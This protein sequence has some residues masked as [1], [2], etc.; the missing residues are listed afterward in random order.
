MTLDFKGLTCPH[1]I[2]ESKKILDKMEEGKIMLMI[3]NCLGTRDDIYSWVKETKNEIVEIQEKD[4]GTFYF[5]IKKG[6]GIAIVPDVT[7]D[8][9]G[10][11]YPCPII[12]SKRILNK[13][14]EGKIMLM[15]SDCPG[16]RD[17]VETC[18]NITGNELLDVHEEAR[19]V[20]AF[21]IK[22]GKR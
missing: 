6:K 7:L 8:F 4:K 21:Y 20:Y 3:S 12:E 10:L 18:V 2:I 13:M 9:R 5:Y 22:K 19:G 14:E 11:T 1:P 15:I 17:D 16:T